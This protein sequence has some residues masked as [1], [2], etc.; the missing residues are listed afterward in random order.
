MQ[1]QM[2]D[3]YLESVEFFNNSIN[4]VSVEVKNKNKTFTDFNLT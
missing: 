3:L 2:L 4:P 1:Q